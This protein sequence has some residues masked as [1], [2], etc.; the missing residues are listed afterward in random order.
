LH[1]GRQFSATIGVGVRKRPRQ[2]VKPEKGSRVTF[3][4]R[5]LS[6]TRGAPEKQRRRPTAPG[7]RS[8]RSKKGRGTRQKPKELNNGHDQERGKGERL[9]KLKKKKGG[10]RGSWFLSG[11]KKKKKVGTPGRRKKNSNTGEQTILVSAL[12]KMGGGGH[13][14]NTK[15]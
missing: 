15:S 4:E 8:N 12:C 14:G 1:R 3:C 11:E 7:S 10:E 9:K 6:Q 5:N 13:K 2:K